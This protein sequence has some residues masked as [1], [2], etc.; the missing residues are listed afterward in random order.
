MSMVECA[1]A[2][3]RPD[4]RIRCW[5]KATAGGVAIGRLSGVATARVIAAVKREAGMRAFE[6]GWSLGCGR[7]QKARP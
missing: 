7:V 5:P 2:G 4:V 6:D 1:D 3:L